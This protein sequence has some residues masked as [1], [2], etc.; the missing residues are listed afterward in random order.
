MDN[1][2]EI[3]QAVNNLN[4]IELAILRERILVIAEYVIENKD[5][6]QEQLQEGFISPEMYIAACERI[7]E[8]FNFKDEE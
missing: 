6:F 3:I 7:F 2:E 1:R 5:T 8:E 4:D